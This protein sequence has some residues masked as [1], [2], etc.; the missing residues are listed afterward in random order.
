MTSPIFVEFNVNASL[1]FCRKS[2]ALLGAVS[3]LGGVT[4]AQAAVTSMLPGAW[5]SNTRVLI[6]S[7]DST[8]LL[9]KV[10]MDM[11]MMLPAGMKEQAIATLNAANTRVKTST[12]ISAATA[13]ANSTPSA[14]F[15]TLSK[16][17][18]RCTFTLGRAT[19]YAQLFSGRCDDPSS[20]TGNVT[21]KIYMGSAKSWRTDFSGIGR[22]PDAALA[23]LGL[24]AGSSVQMQTIT[25]SSWTSAT[26]P[27]Q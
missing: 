13:A 23:A 9:Q 4:V 25:L 3:M 6:N 1:K 14:L 2:V 20:F 21:G 27:A 19:N 16:M 26:C 12:C 22:V 5:S 15:A 8:V 10:Q 18:P 24:P 17:N 7:K 11:A